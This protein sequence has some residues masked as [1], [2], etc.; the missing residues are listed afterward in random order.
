MGDEFGHLLEEGLLLFLWEF[1]HLL[2]ELS[3]LSVDVDAAESVEA[4]GEGLFELLAF[5]E[6]A[7][8]V[9]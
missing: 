6:G 7:F 2:S 9:V 1:G 4:V 3:E 8:L 5:G